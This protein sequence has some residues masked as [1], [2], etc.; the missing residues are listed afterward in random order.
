MSEAVAFSDE[1]TE[2]WLTH[3]DDCRAGIA[4]RFSM[5]SRYE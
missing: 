3:G 4:I 5:R 2:T 1:V